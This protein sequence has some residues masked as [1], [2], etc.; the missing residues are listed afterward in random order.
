M[1]NTV[2]IDPMDGR[3]GAMSATIAMPERAWGI[4]VF[5]HGGGNKFDVPRDRRLMD[6]LHDLGLATMLV[7]LYSSAE[8]RVAKVTSKDR[9]DIALMADRLYVAT[10]WIAHHSSNQD[11]KI[12][13]LGTG[14]GAAAALQTAA[15]R[16]DIAAVVSC[17]GLP[18]LAG[19]AL[20]DVAAATL[21]IV[22][23]NDMPVIEWNIPAYERLTRAYRRELATVSDAP[24]EIA[25]LAGRW[26]LR[27]LGAAAA[28]NVQRN[29]MQR[30]TPT[31]KPR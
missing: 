30:G 22:N 17:N 25:Q 10:D 19:N 26:F 31:I 6:S 7:D 1:E 20:C 14:A 18:A 13:Y 28:A 15:E 11:L 27:Y 9:V 24:H 21:L 29:R 3:I 5:A 12:G 23:E 4:V 8:E 16:S 2:R